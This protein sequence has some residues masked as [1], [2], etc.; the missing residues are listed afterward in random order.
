M[1]ARIGSI[2]SLISVL[3]FLAIVWEGFASQRPVLARKAR[4]GSLE[5]SH[6]FPPINHRYSSCPKIISLSVKLYKLKGS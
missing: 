3:Y 1:V 4:V 2:I 5:L 6:S